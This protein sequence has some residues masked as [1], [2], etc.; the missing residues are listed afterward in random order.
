MFSL[1]FHQIRKYQYSTIIPLTLALIDFGII[2]GTLYF[3]NLTQFIHGIA[4]QSNI[5]LGAKL[6]ICW[7]F[8]G[9]IVNTY[10]IDNLNTY[11]KILMGSAFTALVYFALI[12]LFIGLKTDSELNLGYLPVFCFLAFLFNVIVRM[13]LLHFYYYFRPLSL[14]RKKAIILG[15]TFRGNVLSKYFLTNT[16]LNQQYL[17]FFDD[18]PPSE[19]EDLQFFLGKLDKV[20]PYCL[21]KDVNEIYYALDN[22][23]A[24]LSE[25]TRF[26]DE[27]FIFLGIIPDVEGLDVNKRVDTVLYNDSRI[28]VISSKKVPLQLMVNFY[29]KRTF[30]VVFSGFLLFALSVSVFPVI[31]FAIK[32]SS[33]GPVFFKQLR[34]GR[35]NQLFWCYKFRTMKVNDRTDT[36]AFKGDSRITKVGAFLRK[37]SLDE[38]PQF[39]NV[40]KGE[41]SVVGP[42][43]NLVVHLQNYP[44][45]I[46]DYP[47]RHWITPGITGYAQVSGYRGETKELNQMQKRVEYDLRYIENWRFRFDIIIIIRTVWNIIRGE[48]KAY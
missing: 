2:L 17:G 24:F 12:T 33:P 44:K 13:A 47:Q 1:S 38:L 42:R 48:E 35:N 26:A 32:L 9:L 39:Y 18:R 41:M 8:S 7:I 22:N 3:L 46:R 45:D 19:P 43:P 27:N 4:V 11:K 34:P 6:S 28:P 14:N 23:R 20:M 16:S 21:E 31:A 15:N 5:L 29:I 25:L 36:Q 40:L 37:T 30:D 10:Q